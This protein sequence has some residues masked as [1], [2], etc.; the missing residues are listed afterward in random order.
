MTATLPIV[1]RC[2]K[3]G[4][5]FVDVGTQTSATLRDPFYPH[6]AWPTKANPDVEICGGEIEL[7]TCVIHK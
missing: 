3:C 7:L 1:A 2:K 4:R 5:G 6:G